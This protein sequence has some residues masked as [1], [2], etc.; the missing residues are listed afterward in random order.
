MQKRLY[1]MFYQLVITLVKKLTGQQC[2]QPYNHCIVLEDET[3]GNPLYA[4]YEQDPIEDLAE[5]E[6]LFFA[7]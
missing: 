3:Q 1:K 5:L 2:P 6:H 7:K 4:L